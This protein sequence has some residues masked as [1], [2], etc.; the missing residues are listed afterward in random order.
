MMKRETEDGF[1]GDGGTAG[2]KPK[3]AGTEKGGMYPPDGGL[4]EPTRS[5]YETTSLRQVVRQHFLGNAGSRM[6]D[7]GS[8]FLGAGG[9]TYVDGDI[10]GGSVI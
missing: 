1:I 4:R 7:G 5:L 10:D 2:S 9:C 6:I 8:V 3:C